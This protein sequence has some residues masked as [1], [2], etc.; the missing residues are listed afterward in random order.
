MNHCLLFKF[1]FHLFLRWTSCVFMRYEN[2]NQPLLN[3]IF[4]CN[5]KFAISNWCSVFC[6]YNFVIVMI[7]VDTPLNFINQCIGLFY[8]FELITACYT[9]NVF[10]YLKSTHGTF[11][12]TTSRQTYSFT[13]HVVQAN[14]I[15]CWRETNTFG[16]STNVI[17]YFI[18]NKSVVLNP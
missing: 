3:Y 4:L 12:I 17:S 15:V 9:I 13:C 10:I 8:S 14:A 7:W 18:S 16:L 11:N 5:I 6:N 2:G 1:I